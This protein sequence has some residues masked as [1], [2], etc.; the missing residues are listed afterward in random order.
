MRIATATMYQLATQ[1]LL[2]QQA[3]LAKSQNQIATGK[4]V[5]TPSDDP[6]AAVQLHELARAQ[7]QY[8]Q[9]DKNST[10]VTGRLQLEEQALPMNQTTLLTTMET[11]PTLLSPPELWSR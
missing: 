2:S 6:V 3:A 10:A 9:Y 8:E 11:S 7:S 4:R 1:A 5:Q